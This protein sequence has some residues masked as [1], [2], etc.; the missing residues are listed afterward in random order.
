MKMKDFCVTL[1]TP[2]HISLITLWSDPCIYR[3]IYLIYIILLGS[4]GLPPISI[5]QGL[6]NTLVFNSGEGELIEIL[7]SHHHYNFTLC[8]TIVAEAS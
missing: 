1:K 4:Y 7:W 6:P 3:I 2:K 5:G 8:H